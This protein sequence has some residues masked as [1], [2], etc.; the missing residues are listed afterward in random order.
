MRSGPA[1]RSVTYLPQPA[2]RT[3][4]SF[5]GTTGADN[6]DVEG[7]TAPFGASISIAKALEPDVLI[8]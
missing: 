7:K 1:S 3:G 4:A 2:S 8:A 5:V 6:V